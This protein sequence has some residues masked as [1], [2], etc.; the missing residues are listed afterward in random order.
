MLKRASF[1]PLAKSIV[2]I[3]IG[4]GPDYDLLL[5]ASSFYS[6]ALLKGTI[7]FKMFFFTH[8][9]SLIKFKYKRLPVPLEFRPPGISL[10]LF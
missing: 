8:R 7:Y 10:Q 3:L 4:P 1:L 2:T 6:E 5:K 9:Y